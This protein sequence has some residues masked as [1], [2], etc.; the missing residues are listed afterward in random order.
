M[1]KEIFDIMAIKSYKLFCAN[2]ISDLLPALNV[3]IR[4]EKFLK[5]C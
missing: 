1:E 3:E 4:Y 5:Y 2:E